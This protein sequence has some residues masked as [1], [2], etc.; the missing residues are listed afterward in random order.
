MD[1]ASI[2]SAYSALKALKEIGGSILSAKVDSEA[3]LKVEKMLSEVGAIQ[4]T[5]FY[6]REELLQY[7]EKNRQLKD[8]IRTLEE[9]IKTSE[10][11]IWDEPSYWVLKRDQKEGS[12]CQKC[13]DAN[14][15]LI[16]LQK[17]DPGVWDC[18][19]CD[20]RYYDADYNSDTNEFITI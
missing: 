12:F 4:D 7:Q 8:E 9:M 5:L 15:K 16:R 20:K 1:V 10:E 6:V 18:H 14:K 19:E 2:S 17:F 3:K 11:V 13:Y